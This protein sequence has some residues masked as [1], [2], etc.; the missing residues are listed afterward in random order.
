MQKVGIIGFGRFGQ[1]LYK[2]LCDD[3]E[4]H[5]YEKNKRVYHNISVGV[6]KKIKIHDTPR[7][8][9][10]T[11][12]TVFYCIPASIFEKV[13]EDH[14]KF[15]NNHLLIDTLEVKVHALKI[16]RKNLSKKNYSRAILTY[17]IIDKEKSSVAFYNYN[18]EVSEYGFWKDYFKNK[19]LGI[20]EIDPKKYDRL[21]AKS[22]G[23]VSFVYDLL[24]EINF[25][26]TPLDNKVVK[27]LHELKDQTENINFDFKYN[28]FMK[29]VR[30]SLNSAYEK[31]QQNNISTVKGSKELVYGIQG[32]KG[33]FNEEAV[34]SF[35]AKENIK[36]A[37]TKYLYTSE[38]VLRSL[39]R[40]DIDFGVFAV[41]STESI[42][43]MSKYKFKI[44]DELFIPI[45]YCL[46]K[47]SGTDY[48]DID[49]II[50]HPQSLKECSISLHKN[51]PKLKLI[52][53]EGNL[54]DVANAA[55]SLYNG[56]LKN[57]IA[58]LGSK[59]LAD[60]Y[61]FDIVAKDLQDNDENLT[62]FLI[63][64]RR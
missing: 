48:K 34:N 10:K 36:N 20:I 18:A 11:V 50:A 30:L 9:F 57:N 4:V 26:K 42:Q 53:G 46:M 64:K 19:K 58:I 41:G 54:I 33:S 59:I 1:V 3:F 22:L 29:D 51:Y 27:I 38:N 2:L 60:I 13:I 49:T 39:N 63:V 45:K 16:F 5:V 32:G 23:V 7:Q 14:Q 21:M 12:N 40:G 31:F 25:S 15:F 55:K 35:F 52:S 17:L 24:N 8:L 37:K 44:V 47:K 28:A 43:A 62:T 56:A 6:L 61:N